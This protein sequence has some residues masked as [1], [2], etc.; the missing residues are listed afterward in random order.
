MFRLDFKDHK[1]INNNNSSIFLKK[2][3]L[4]NI[5]FDY[6]HNIKKNLTKDKNSKILEV[7]SGPGLITK[8]IKKCITSEN[9]KTSNLD[10]IENIYN[11]TFNDNELSDIVM[12]DV[13]HHIKYPM[14]AILEMSR[15]LKKKGRIIML[16]PS[17]GYIPRLIFHIFHKEPNG[18][19]FKISTRLNIGLNLDDYF[20]AQSYPYRIFYKNEIDYSDYFSKIKIELKS[21]FAFLGSGGYGYSQFYPSNMYN[22]FKKLDSFLSLFPQIF[23]A[24]MLIVI[25]NKK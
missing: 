8:I 17:M 6:Y 16:E 3:L 20:A 24:R 13:F 11:L 15:V 22:I 5:Y 21:D 10:R 4:Q 18:F 23:A 25:E 7:G 19:N 1:K 9:F 12:I 14:K 2:K